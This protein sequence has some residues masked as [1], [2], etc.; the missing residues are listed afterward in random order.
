MLQIAINKEVTDKL[1]DFWKSFFPKELAI[2]EI[3][4]IIL[5]IS[6][7]NFEQLLQEYITKEDLLTES[8]V[9]N[10]IDQHETI[11]NI[12]QNI[13]KKYYWVYFYEP[14]LKKYI[15]NLIEV[16][17][18]SNLI[19]DKNL[20]LEMAILQICNQL[21]K[22][23]F[24]TIIAETFYA[25]QS[26]LLQGSNAMERGIYYN[27]VLLRNNKYKKG[28]YAD[29]PELT[30]LLDIKVKSNIEFIIKIIKDTEN[31]IDELEKVLNSEEKLGKIREFN[32]GEGDTHNN[33]RSVTKIIFNTNKI[34]MYKPHTLDIEKKYYEFIQWI[35]EATINIQHKLL[36]VKSYSI[37]DAGWTEYIEYEACENSEQLKSFYNK[38]GILLCLL[39]TTKGMDIHYENIIAKKDMPVIIDLET[40]IHPDLFGETGFK[41]AI[42]IAVKEISDSVARIALLPTHITSKNS[43]KIYDVGGLGANKQQESVFLS[44]FIENYGTDEVKIKKMHSVIDV[45]LNNPSIKGDI[46]DSKC[47]REDIVN[48]FKN[49]Y[50]WILENKVLYLDKV[51]QYFGD[52]IARAIYRP[53]NV[54]G[55]ILYSS[56]HPDLLTNSV[57]RMIFLH[58][59]ALSDY[60]KNYKTIILEMKDMLQGDIPYF[61]VEA[62]KTEV[63]GVYSDETKVKLELEN[64]TI[65]SI[66]KK[67]KKMN[68]VDMYRQIAV[69]NSKLD[70][71]PNKE[72]TKTIFKKTY[73]RKWSNNEEIKVAEIIA[74]YLLERSVTIE[75]EEC[76]DRTWFGSEEN[77]FGLNEFKPIN[78]SL[79]SG[80]A[81]IALFFNYLGIISKKYK[82]SK[83]TKEICNSLIKY[84]PR[85][86]DDKDI[87]LLQV[88]A[89]TG[90]S[91]I[92]YVLFYIDYSNNTNYYEEQINKILDLINDKIRGLTKLDVIADV[93]IIGVLISIYTKIDNVLMKN[94]ALELSKKV[95]M[96]LK[97]SS[98][99]IKDI[100]GITW[101]QKGYVGYAHGNAGII[102]QIYRL[103]NITKD[104]SIKILAE[105][106]M[107]FERASYEETKNNWRKT[108]EADLC[109]CAWCH[110]APGI[111]MSKL[112]L[113]RSGMADEIINKEI[114]VAI[115]ST[116]KDGLKI[117]WCL[118]HGDMGNLAIL[119]EAGIILNDDKLY[120]QAVC[121]IEDFIEYFLD[122]MNTE[123]FKE[124]EHNGLMTGLAG[125]GYEI[126][127]INREHELPNV[128]ALE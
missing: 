108:I 23:A 53:T 22:I 105:Q 68:E 79:Y 123:Q 14:V 118:C 67:I 69:I 48:G 96:K 111:L 15:H 119:K 55:Q 72:E 98:I 34:I 42:E 110:G 127:R 27:E 81:G 76:S 44:K 125:I 54:Y 56:Y 33:G 19:D 120:K 61:T 112:Q 101:N 41:S 25:K 20:F 109:S 7:K 93:G 121:S 70:N 106:A 57:D 71:E 85:K 100:P 94:K 5:I 97:D 2:S 82:Y 115:D 30:R 12:L 78:F 3:E 122:F 32:M 66:A 90:L 126:L 84:I 49:M 4:E 104:E 124:N 11:D 128:L 51:I 65:D 1:K 92:L 75:T 21:H 8:L 113:L 86:A 36:A 43:G 31:E 10:D 59:L 60:E 103:Y 40:F 80:L 9:W 52:T 114:E 107:L 87:E 95:F 50:R 116:I 6:G 45:K 28:I 117:H 62:S 91:G 102:A 37:E 35:N 73:K 64:S 18:K 58:R 88:G 16:V 24:Q 29:Y 77:E 99:E 39:Y 63:C 83:I 47:F 46:A 26:N 74:D 38:I 13:K 89:F 17:D